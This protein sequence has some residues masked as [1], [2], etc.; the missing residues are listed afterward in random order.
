MPLSMPL[1]LKGVA[2]CHLFVFLIVGGSG[3]FCLSVFT[4]LLFYFILFYFYFQDLD[5]PDIPVVVSAITVLFSLLSVP[6]S[7]PSGGENRF[8]R[9]LQ[10][11]NSKPSSRTRNR[12]E[13]SKCR[14]RMLPRK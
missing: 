4:W 2:L 1:L 6:V 11:N 12:R 14:P 5:I 7:S 8:S 9:K 10:G 13:N 3:S